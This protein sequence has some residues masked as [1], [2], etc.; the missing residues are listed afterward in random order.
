[1]TDQ[2]AIAAL[3]KIHSWKLEHISPTTFP[4]DIVVK[5]RTLSKRECEAIAGTIRGGRC[6][7]FRI[8]KGRYFFGESIA[9]VIVAALQRRKAKR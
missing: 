7:R 9:E 6:Y 8:G 4:Q 5:I 1:M 2:K 3:A